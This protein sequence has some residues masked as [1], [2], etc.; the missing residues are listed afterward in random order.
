M[1]STNKYL[2]FSQSDE[3]EN[4]FQISMGKRMIQNKIHEFE[5]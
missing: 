5:L 2:L 3:F 1:L 4:E